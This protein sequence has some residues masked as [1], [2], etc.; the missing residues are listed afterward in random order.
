MADLGYNCCQMP[1][2]SSYK[3]SCLERIF[4]VFG[5]VF[6]KQQVHLH[7]KPKHLTF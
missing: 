7:T 5:S 6:T 1:E 2:L 4:R 3:T